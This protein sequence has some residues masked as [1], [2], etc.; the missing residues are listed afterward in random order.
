MFLAHHEWGLLHEE[1]PKNQALFFFSETMEM[2]NHTSTFKQESS[3]PIP[4]QYINSKEYLMVPLKYSVQ[5][6]TDAIVK[7]G[8]APVL[9]IQSACNP[10][11]DRDVYVQEL[12]KYIKVDSYGKCLNNKQIP[13]DINSPL[14]M[15]D[16]HFR[17][18]VKKYKF[19]IAMEN[20]ICNDYM[21]EKLFRTLSAG[22]V[23]IYKGAPNILDWMPNNHSIILVDN[24]KGPKELADYISHLDKNPEEYAKY[25]EYKTKGISNQKLL[26][27]LESRPWGVNNMY[28]MSFI[29]GFECHVCDRIHANRKLVELGKEPIKHIADLSHYGCPKPVR[30]DY[31][32]LPGTEEWERSTWSYE[33]EE[34]KTRAVTLKKKVLNSS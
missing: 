26:D 4:S 14:M 25:T 28:K 17:E 5:E 9:Y 34:G 24:F 19:V 3:Y 1:S 32:D 30:Y 33:Y 12:M 22:S 15:H 27:H 21:T 20:A 11:S 31:P 7:E 10:P 23:P 16:A 29:T 6:K 8:I 13:K 18:F 2:F